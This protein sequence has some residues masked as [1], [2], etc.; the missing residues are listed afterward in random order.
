MFGLSVS[1]R[2]RLEVGVRVELTGTAVLIR[3][4][5]ER[6]GCSSSQRGSGFMTLSRWV[7]VEE[8]IVFLLLI[9]V[10]MR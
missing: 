3:S 2:V 1:I 7:E 5:V 9:L 6:K 10:E 8:Y 4:V